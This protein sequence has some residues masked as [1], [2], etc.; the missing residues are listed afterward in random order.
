MQKGA[1]VTRSRRRSLRGRA[2]QPSE[3]ESL[4]PAAG[5]PWHPMAP[6]QA[7]PL[8]PVMA[9]LLSLSLPPC[10]PTPERSR[11]QSGLSLL[12]LSVHGVSGMETLSALLV[13]C[14]TAL[15]AVPLSDQPVASS[16]H[17]LLFYTYAV[18]PKYIHSVLKQVS[19]SCKGCPAA[20]LRVLSATLL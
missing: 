2:E 1:W 17:I 16:L 10:P 20:G 18:D 9:G 14:H 13:P 7:D 15:P 4:V 6:M 8:P 5:G 19:F 12:W 11:G 3:G